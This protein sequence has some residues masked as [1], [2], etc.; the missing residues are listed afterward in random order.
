MEPGAGEPWP[1]GRSRYAAC[2]LGYAG[3]HINLLVTGGIGRGD[4]P[5]NDTWLFNLSSK[6][7]KEARRY[8]QHA[9]Y[10][11]CVLSHVQILYTVFLLK[12][13]HIYRISS[14]NPALLIIRHPLPDD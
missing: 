14:K 1:A 7:W 3:D 12:I 6:K 13:R 8:Y 4:K 2:C 9:I 5:L 11:V 10:G